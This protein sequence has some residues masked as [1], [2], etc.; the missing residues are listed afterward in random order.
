MPNS[1]ARGGLASSLG[2]ACGTQVASALDR[3]LDAA[4]RRSRAHRAV[5]W[6][7]CTEVAIG[8]GAGNARL[9]PGDRFG[10]SLGEACGTQVFGGRPGFRRAPFS[11]ASGGWVGALHRG[12]QRSWCRQRPAASRLQGRLSPGGSLRNPGVWRPSW[13]P[14]GAAC[15]RIGRLVGRAAPGSPSAAVLATPGSI[16][17][18]RSAVG[19]SLGGACGTQ[20]F[21]RRPGFR[22][23]PFAGASDCWLGLLHR[24][25]QRPRCR[26]RP[27]PSRLH[28]RL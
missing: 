26:Q 25:R 2:G 6:A 9:H 21:G 3:V 7:R 28:A 27:A 8:R 1:V 13:I 16:Q 24:G 10:C 15:W 18:S 14:P 20:V 12:R 4:G 22:R 23:A 5:G 17:A 19:C 11:G